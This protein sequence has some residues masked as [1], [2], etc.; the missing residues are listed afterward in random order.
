MKLGGL[1]LLCG[2]TILSG[3]GGPASRQLESMLPNSMQDGT[4]CLGKSSYNIYF[5]NPICG[6]YSILGS[7]AVMTAQ[8]ADG[9]DANDPTKSHAIAFVSAALSDSRTKCQNFISLFTG[10]QSAENTGFDVTAIILSGLASVFTPANTVRALAAASTAVQGTKAAVDSDLYQQ[11]TMLLLVQQINSTYYSEIDSYSKN[12]PPSNLSAF[13]ASNALQTIQGYHKDCSIP[14]AAASISANQAK[15]ASG[16]PQGPTPAPKI[17]LSDLK[18]G[19]QKYKGT[20]PGVSGVIY[21]V[22]ATTTGTGATAK[23]TYSY[24]TQEGAGQPGAQITIDGNALIDL[25]NAAGAE[26]SS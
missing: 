4:S 1:V 22:A 14:F 3:C 23:T 11:M 26:P 12:F 10:S 5:A 20:N 24:Q 9:A 2:A 16:T 25:L 15:S 19:T 17:A 18:P 21:I 13:S 7:P 6:N 8:Q